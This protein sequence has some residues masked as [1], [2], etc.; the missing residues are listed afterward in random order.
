VMAII[1]NSIKK[2]QQFSKTVTVSQVVS[3]L[4]DAGICSPTANAEVML[5][6]LLDL[7]TVD[8][9]TSTLELTK[10]EF[11]LLEQMITRRIDG[12]P[13]Q[14]I[15][16]KMNFYGN[17]IIIKKG[18]FIPRPETEILVDAVIAYVQN[19]QLPITNYGSTS[20]PSL[21]SIRH[22]DIAQCGSKCGEYIEPP[23][24]GFVPS[25]S[26]DEPSRAKPRDQLRILDLCTGSGNIAI[27]LTKALTHC[28]IISS[29]ISETA[30]KTVTENAKINGV[31]DRIVCIKADFLS[32]P[33]EYKKTF[34]II[35]CNPP[36]V[37]YADMK[38]LTIEVKQDPFTALCGGIDGM[39]FYRRIAEDSG[40][41][42]K[43]RGFIALEIPDNGSAEVKKIID[44]SGNFSDIRFF[45]DLNGIKR[46]VTVRF[47][48]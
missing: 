40:E 27:S 31:S 16:G 3:R 7:R 34:D 36:Y 28:K 30:L 2:L 41:F 1:N 17:D 45:N 25:L 48:N 6:C 20:S 38:G 8:L 13:I 46:V 39:D 29:D 9:Y 24:P 18:V 19:Y 47:I 44:D 11:L 37:R 10:E 32:L 14:H 35:V 12:E 26:K 4:R 42:L 15:T 43:D 33:C 21:E 5:S 23:R 22:F